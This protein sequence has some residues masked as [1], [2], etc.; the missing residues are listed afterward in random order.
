MQVK[1]FEVD[2]NERVNVCKL[3]FEEVCRQEREKDRKIFKEEIE[4]KVEYMEIFEMKSMKFPVCA[5][6][7][8]GRVRLI[9]QPE[10]RGGLEHY[11][12]F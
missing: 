5:A 3:K 6:L 9:V 2:T 7:L 8:L 1:F 12:L 11:D 4:R 10:F